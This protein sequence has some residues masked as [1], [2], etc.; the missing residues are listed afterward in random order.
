MRWQVAWLL[1]FNIASSVAFGD[2]VSSEDVEVK[3]QGESLEVDPSVPMLPSATKEYVL[4]GHHRWQISDI[5][6]SRT[7]SLK[8]T[9]QVGQY[10]LML[11]DDAE[12]G[13][14]AEKACRVDSS[15]LRQISRGGGRAL[16][17]AR[18]LLVFICTH[19]GCLVL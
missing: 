14:L 1:A 2:V 5:F 9:K 13:L 12:F 3:T 17:Q 7:V 16:R 10:D 19:L 18:I 8:C 6:T 4:T 15:V 11:V